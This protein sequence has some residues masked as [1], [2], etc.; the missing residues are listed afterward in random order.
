MSR[1]K[2]DVTIGNVNEVYD[3]PGG[4]LWEMLMGDQIHVGGSEETGILAGKAG[5]D[6]DSHV[7][8]VCSALG[9]PARHLVQTYGCRVTGLDATRRMH[10]EAIRRTKEAGLDG[11]IEYRLGNALDMPFPA[12]TFDVVW[13]Q[14]AWCYITDKKRLVEECARVLKPGGVLAFTD[15]LETGP[16]TED[17][18]L[19]LNTFMVFPYMETLEG[20]AALCESAGL[21]VAE[22]EDLS[23]DFAGN[24]QMYLEKLQNDLRQGVIDNYGLEMYDEVERGITLW[25]DASAAGKVGRG[26]ILARK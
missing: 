21:N 20:Y 24:I 12:N 19:A 8:D 17:E 26:R 11:R 13:G 2:L 18:W 9:G 5:I 22:K 1:N 14:D 10:E 25:R 4:I 15:W 6:P 23:T 7:L 16:M 3:G